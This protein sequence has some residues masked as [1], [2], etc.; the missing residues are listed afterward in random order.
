MKRFVE[1]ENRSQSTLFP[2]LLDDYV[3]EDNPV[4]VID[5]FVDEL[6][7]GGIGFSGVE[8][9]AMT[10]ASIGH[11]Y[12]QILGLGLVEHVFFNSCPYIKNLPSAKWTEI[13]YP[14]NQNRI[15]QP[16]P[17]SPRVIFDSFRKFFCG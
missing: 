12:H 11:R 4:R 8:P 1:G 9:L 15:F 6:D 17:N 13:M 14:F 7:L 5:A 3:R 10:N 2:E 16:I